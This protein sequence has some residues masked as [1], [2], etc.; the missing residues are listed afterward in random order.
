MI[1]RI[2]HFLVVFTSVLPKDFCDCC[3]D[4]FLRV[5]DWW[6]REFF[7]SEFLNCFLRS[8]LMHF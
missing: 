1:I 8:V 4:Y 7:F 2:Y 6:P 5:M 3:L